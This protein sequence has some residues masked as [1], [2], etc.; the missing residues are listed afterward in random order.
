MVKTDTPTRSGTHTKQ[1]PISFCT[2]IVAKVLARES[3]YDFI[4]Y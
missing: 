2:P 1:V 4:D 3:D